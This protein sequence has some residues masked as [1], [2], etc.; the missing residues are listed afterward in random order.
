MKKINKIGLGGILVFSLLA[1]CNKFEEINTDPN[2]TTQVSA[3]LLCTNNILSITQFNSDAAAFIGSNT[4]PKY[5]GYANLGQSDGQ[6]N[7]LGSSYFGGMTVLPN[8]EK[9]VQY[10]KT[11]VPPPVQNSYEGVAKFVKAWMFYRL[12]LEMGDIPYSKAG[13][14]AEGESTPKYDSQESILIGVLDE[15]KAADQLFANGGTFLGDPTPYKGDPNKWRRATN[16][17]ALKILMTLSKK[18]DV[19][20]LNVKTRFAEIVAGGF[21]MEN[22]TG[23]FGLAYSAINKHPFSGTSNMFT[24][25]TLLTTVMV[26]NLKKLNDWRLFYWAEPAGAQLTAG[27]TQTDTAAY[28]GVDPSIDYS[29]MNA[30]WGSN[31]YSIINKRYLAE[32]ATEPRM[33]LTFAEQQL[34][35]A[36]ARIKGWIA[37]GTAEDYYQQGVKAALATVM[38]VNSSYSHTMTINQAYINGYFTGEAAFKSTADEQLK[39]IWMQRYLL[40][41]L[42]DSEYSYFEYRRNHLPLRWTYPNSETLYNRENLVEAINRQYDGY[43]EINKVMWLLK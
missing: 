1:G 43:D 7:L 2:A 15:L 32:V 42:Q 34:V 37:T 5:V 31:A 9:M 17:F 28:V 6:Y 25:R 35:L 22:T 11:N 16:S 39:Q 38:A 26:D 29:L 3:A 4:L 10:A 41:F 30:G 24:S 19:A 20:S 18:E 33:L 21:L 36:E 8:I 40:N 12:T 14:G 27:K 23:Y 13:L